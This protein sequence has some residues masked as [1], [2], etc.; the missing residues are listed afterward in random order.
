[1]PRG[2]AAHFQRAKSTHSAEQPPTVNLAKSVACDEQKIELPRLLRQ[3]F[4]KQLLTSMDWFAA[5]LRLVA[6]WH[7]AYAIGIVI[8][9]AALLQVFLQLFQL[10]RRLRFEKKQQR[11]AA[12]EMQLSIRAAMLRCQQ[13]EQAQLVWNGFRKFRVAKKLLECKDVYSFYLAPHDGKK[14]PAFRPGQYLTF[15]LTIPNQNKPVIRCYSIS[16][17]P[18]QDNQFR[19]TIKRALPPRDAVGAPAGLASTYFADH[20]QEGDIVDVKAPGGVFFL[21]LQRSTPVVLISGG[22]GITPMLSMLNA[23]INAGSKREIWFF[24]GA[25]NSSEHI[26]KEYLERIAS[27]HENVHLFVS[28][29]CPQP[30][31]VEGKDYQHKGYFSVSLLKDLLPSN[32]FEFFI[33]GPPKMME[34]SARLLEDWGVP[35]NRINFEAFGASTRKSIEKPPS[36]TETKQMSKLKVV[37]ARSGKTAAWNPDCESLLDF[38]E[39]LGIEVNSG[40]RSGSCGTCLV[41]VKS[42][43]VEY[44]GA[45]DA[46]GEEGSCLTC[47]CRPKTDLSLDA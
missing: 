34:D 27:Q 23:L 8:I 7:I 24:H 18:R 15:Q 42:G 43:S 12:E 33:C 10:S 35:R 38:A 1:V 25:R 47:I 6:S 16:D 31:D 17:A 20:L 19:V 45:H 46:P 41:A 37:F 3:P 28:Y 4:V 5:Q 11:L 30:D 32:N 2:D 44:S 14:I 40:C 29:S 22:V 9:S 36:A 13:S 39:Q 21:D 26:Q